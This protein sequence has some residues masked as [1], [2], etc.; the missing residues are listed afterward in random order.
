MKF[1]V[2]LLK[3]YSKQSCQQVVDW[4]GDSATR[5]KQLV[6]VL[7]GEDPLLVQRAAW[8]FTYVVQ[9]HPELIHAHFAAVLDRMEEDGWHDAVRRNIVR[10][11]EYVKLN[12]RTEGRVMNTCFRFLT[13]PSEKAAVKASCITVLGKLAEKYPE[14]KPELETAIRD[15]WDREGASFR[16]RA[17]QVLGK[18]K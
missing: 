18:L 9:Q 16:A 7:T 4:V 10:A 11:L 1:P 12:T 17:R 8:P 15:Q 5:F 3:S 13:D 14:I 2:E 6:A